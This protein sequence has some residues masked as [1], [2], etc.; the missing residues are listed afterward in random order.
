MLGK[1]IKHEFKATGRLILPLF[2]LVIVM[3]PV[4]ALLNK[5][6]SHIGKNH[7]V[8]R[9]LSGISMGSF[10]ADDRCLA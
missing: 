1:M 9:I 6:A 3:T 7:L 10:V 2:L 5:L 8:G 4:L